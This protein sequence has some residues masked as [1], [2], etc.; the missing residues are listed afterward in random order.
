MSQHRNAG[1][2]PRMS[3]RQYM[4]TAFGG[5][6]MLGVGV[7]LASS[8]GA[9]APTTAAVELAS[10]DLPLPLGPQEPWWL[11]DSANPLI[12]SAASP[13]TNALAAA[14]RDVGTSKL[15]PI[16]GPG[17]WLIG[18]GLD[19][20]ADCTGDACNGGNGGLFGGSGGDGANGG[21]GGNG[22]WFF[23]DGGNGGNG[24]NAVYDQAGTRIS[25]ATDGGDG[26]N[27]GRLSG[28]G[29]NGGN[30]GNDDGEPLASTTTDSVGGNGGNGGN[31]ASGLSVN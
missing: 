13:T 8:P 20:P 23:G 11:F 15:R 24:L 14:S 29:G 31:A 22:G 1:R 30:G 18:D 4:T 5:A 10:T 12:G 21:D 27:A 26:G 7:L 28:R 25:A 2:T 9:P 16:I 17:G 19:A 3:A 6:A